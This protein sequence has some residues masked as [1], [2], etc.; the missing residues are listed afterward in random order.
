[1]Q[2]ISFVSQVPVIGLDLL[3]LLLFASI[4]I[5]IYI[6]RLYIPVFFWKGGVGENGSTVAVSL[7]AQ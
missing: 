3:S 4:L 7:L 6:V 2:F 1:M 5:A